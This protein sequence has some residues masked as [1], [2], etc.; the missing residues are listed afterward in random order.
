MMLAGTARV[1]ITPPVGTWQGGYGARTR[2][3]EGVL[4]DLHAR[5]LVLDG[6]D[7]GPKAAVVS[8]DIL[9]LPKERTDRARQLA[10]S[11]SGI[12]AG[13]IALCMSHTHWGPLTWEMEGFHQKIDPEYLLLLEKQ[14][15]GAVAAAARALRPVTARPGRGTAGFNINR[16]RLTPRGVGGPDPEGPADREVLVLRL[17]AVPPDGGARFIQANGVP[18]ALLF[19]YTCHATSGPGLNDGGYCLH[20][21]YPG[22][23]AAFIE[24]SYGGATRALFLQGC[25]GDTRPNLVTPEGRF[26]AGAW[27][28]VQALGRELGTAAIAAAER[29]AFG[30]TPSD[31]PDILAVAGTT[32]LLPFQI[33]SREELRHALDASDRPLSDSG[34]TWAERTL[35]ALEAGTLPAGNPAEVQVFRIG[36]AWLVI[37]PGEVFVEIGWRVRDAVAEAAGVPTANVIVAANA[38]GD[39]G[40]V[41]TAAAMKLGGYE[42]TAHRMWCWPGCYVPEA[43]E[44]LARAAADLAAGLAR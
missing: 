6:G 21:D 40:Y 39:V 3:S 37:L 24:R 44:I 8:L 13:N 35:A 1:R 34:R 25:C 23:A 9:D 28:E 31:T 14:V 4:D 2:P 42:P 43:Q 15:A 22:A 19:R 38:N 20:G 26:R 11:L 29:T 30:Q 32:I 12:P 18:L 36:P 17:D 41:P 7:G 10:E 5:A 27:P 16:R 33:P